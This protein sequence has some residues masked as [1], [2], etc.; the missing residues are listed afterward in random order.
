[1]PSFN[2]NP[3]FTGR[4]TV[5]EDG[6]IV[7]RPLED[8]P[9][10]DDAAIDEMLRGYAR[11]NPSIRHL[12]DATRRQGYTWYA[13]PS[14]NYLGA[15]Y[16]RGPMRVTWYV[17][18]RSMRL[19]FGDEVRAYAVTLPGADLRPDGAVSFLYGGQGG[20][21]EALKATEAVRKWVDDQ[22]Q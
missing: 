22:A 21:D 9:Q 4:I 5:E 7:V 11:L 14:S 18:S 12:F 8:T 6:T 1:M 13:V 19:N 15:F 2:F 20:V 3:G 16:Q 17:N 10:L